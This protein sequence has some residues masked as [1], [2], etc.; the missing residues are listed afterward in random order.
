VFISTDPSSPLFG[1][2]KDLY[3]IKLLLR[4]PSA[5]LLAV[6]HVNT[7]NATIVGIDTMS[8]IPENFKLSYRLADSRWSTPGAAQA[9]SD[10]TSCKAQAFERDA[11]NFLEAA[12]YSRVND[13]GVAVRTTPG[14]EETCKSTVSS[15]T[16][17]GL[18]EAPADSQITAIVGVPTSNN[19]KIVSTI[20]DLQS[21]P[22]MSFAATESVLQDKTMY[23]RFSRT[24]PG[25]RPMIRALVG[26]I[27]HFGWEAINIVNVGNA[28]G[29]SQTSEL[30]D[31]AATANITIAST[32]VFSPLDD[33]SIGKA[34]L[35][36]SR[37]MYNSSASARTRVTVLIAG[38]LRNVRSVLEHGAK[39]KIIQA[40]FVWI[41]VDG[42]NMQNVVATNDMSRELIRSFAG[43]LN[44]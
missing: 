36:L 10:W 26:V 9:I 12:N 7:R 6:H 20:A 27:S 42:N 29:L 8:R 21:I 35:A 23:P 22:V 18:Y 30:L 38:N 5:A 25:T 32:H 4:W 3:W 16:S 44:L 2:D 1:P 28:R 37:A 11:C 24:N 13:A 40:G 43:W 17:S 33:E 39:N 19:A 15:G 14:V 31:E 41:N 34:L